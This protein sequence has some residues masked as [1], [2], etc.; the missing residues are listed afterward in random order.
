MTIV[1][2]AEEFARL[3]HGNID[4]R[5]K[6]T[7]EPYIVHPEAV[8]ATI[9]AIGG[10]D[11]MIAAAWL[12]DVVEDT[13]VTVAQILEEFG[14]DVADLVDDLTNV[15]KPEDGNRAARKALNCEHTAKASARAKTIK[16]ADL[17]DNVPS[18]VTHDPEFAKTY[19]EEKTRQLAVLTEGNI[20]LYRLAEL[21]IISSAAIL[22]K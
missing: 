17:I 15:A 21:I 11:N 16:L 20:V 22:G 13:P 14:T 19:V 1:E 6:Y 8:V 12:H 4:Q 3:W 5:R 10:D 18:I 2:K 7:D 9:I